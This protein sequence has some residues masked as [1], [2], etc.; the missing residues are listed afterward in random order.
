MNMLE[1]LSIV[2]NCSLYSAQMKTPQGVRALKVIDQKL[3]SLLR[4]K[5]WREGNRSIPIHMGADAFEYPIPDLL[6]HPD[7]LRIQVLERMW[8]AC[9]HASITRAHGLFVANLDGCDPLVIRKPTLAELAD[10]IIAEEAASS[11]S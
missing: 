2:R 1:A 11:K 5:A 4:K 6:P 8:K 3:Q 10:A 7:T 9:P